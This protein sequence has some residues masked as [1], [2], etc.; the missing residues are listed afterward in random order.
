[1]TT[2]VVGAA[3]ESAHAMNASLRQAPLQQRAKTMIEAIR[4]SNSS[5]VIA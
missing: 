4:A 2:M 5:S 3:A 1:M